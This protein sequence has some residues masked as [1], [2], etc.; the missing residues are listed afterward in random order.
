MRRAS[1]SL[2]ETTHPRYTH[3][4]RYPEGNQRREK[5]FTSKTTA[6][7]WAK[8]KQVEV[9]NEGLKRELVTEDEKRTLADFRERVEEVDEALKALRVGI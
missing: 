3:V 1:V 5:Y 2:S 4:V 6:S 7:G 8:R 9:Q